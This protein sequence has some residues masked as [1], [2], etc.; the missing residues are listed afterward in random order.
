MRALL[1]F[2][3]LL[4]SV[5]GG[6]AQGLPDLGGRGVIAM[7]DERLPG[8][9]RYEKGDR[10]S[11]EHAALDEIAK[12]LN[13]DIEWKRTDTEAMVPAL[14]NG[15]ADIAID[16]AP[17]GAPRDGPVVFTEPYLVLDQV[18]LARAGSGAVSP[19]DP[20]LTVGAVAGESAKAAVANLL[21][22]DPKSSRLVTF[23]RDSDAAAAVWAGN[24]DVAVVDHLTAEVLIAKAGGE[25]AQISEPIGSE[26]FAFVLA[27]GSDLADAL[28]A[29]LHSLREDGTLRAYTR[30]WMYVWD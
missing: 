5:G 30:K 28:N 24:V 25:I 2:S 21:A 3:A 13:I 11:F 7:I 12:R 18:I 1:G 4:V 26:S 19:T 15:A 10:S 27:E 17:V 22:N 8:K 29:G 9:T 16:R 6:W 23:A 14:V 20:S